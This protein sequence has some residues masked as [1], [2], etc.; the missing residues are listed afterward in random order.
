[1]VDLV[2]IRKKAKRVSGVGSGELEEKPTSDAVVAPPQ[3]AVLLRFA[4]QAMATTFAVIFP[5]GTP[6]AQGAADAALD[7]Q[8]RPLAS[9]LDR[10]QGPALSSGRATS[11]AYPS[12]SRCRNR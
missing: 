6:D 1:M 7:L 9:P 12:T 2:K 8:N 3:D 10:R 4:R 11:T 5:L